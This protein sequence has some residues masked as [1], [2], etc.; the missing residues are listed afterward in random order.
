MILSDSGNVDPFKNTSKIYLRS[1]LATYVKIL[2]RA[3]IL[4]LRDSSSKSVFS[5]NTL[6]WP[7]IY[8]Q[9]LWCHR[10]IIHNMEKLETIYILNKSG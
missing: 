5:W 8:A 2:N 6:K 4:G 10:I 1:N 3:C 7:K 9:T